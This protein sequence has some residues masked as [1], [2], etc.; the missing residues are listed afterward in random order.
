MP[1]QKHCVVLNDEN[2][3]EVCIFRSRA[4]RAVEDSPH[5]HESYSSRATSQIPLILSLDLDHVGPSQT[6]RYFP[7]DPGFLFLN[8]DEPQYGVRPVRRDN[9]DHADAHVEDLIQVIL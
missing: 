1:W 9:R 6:L 8:A 3:S 2:Q 7:D 5:Q 4:G